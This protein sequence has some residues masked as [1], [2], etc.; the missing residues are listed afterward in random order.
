[1]ALEFITVSIK[2]M[3][4]KKLNSN[5]KFILAEIQQLSQ[6]E[7]GCFASNGHFSE[8]IGITKE[9]ASRKSS[10]DFNIRT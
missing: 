2:I 5:Q 10:V 7:Q 8:L 9:C 6:M 4:D 3:H 1:M